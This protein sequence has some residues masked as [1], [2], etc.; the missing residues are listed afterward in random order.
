MKLP[1]FTAEESI[2]KSKGVY[3]TASS[4]IP[5]DG[6]TYLH[7]QRFPSVPMGLNEIDIIRRTVPP[8]STIF[9]VDSHCLNQ[10][11][12][13]QMI[14]RAF[15]PAKCAAYYYGLAAPSDCIDRCER[16]EP[17]FQPDREP[18]APDR[19]LHPFYC[20]KCLRPYHS[21]FGREV[22]SIDLG[23]LNLVF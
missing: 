23:V 10:C 7:P 5:Y 22:G 17:V 12:H 6:R 18:L 9:I 8:T 16:G 1:G 2:Y 21:L 3:I 15:C 19:T 20:L 4:Q 14:R 13:D 11:L